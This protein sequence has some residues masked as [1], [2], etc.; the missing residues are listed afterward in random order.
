MGDLTTGVDLCG[1]G[2]IDGN[3]VC[4]DSNQDDFDGCRSDCS[5]SQ[6]LDIYSGVMGSGTCARVYGGGFRCWGKDDYGMLGYG[7]GGNIGDDELAR[8]GGI[9]KIGANA[10]EISLGITHACARYEDGT[11]RCWGSGQ[12]GALGAGNMMIMGSNSAPSLLDVVALGGE[13]VAQVF[14]GYY[15]TCVRFEVGKVSCW[16]YGEAGALGLGNVDNLGDDEKLTPGSFI[17]LGMA[18]AIQ[19]SMGFQHACVLS[20]EGAVRCWGGNFTGQLGLGHTNDI[21]DDELPSSAPEVSIGGPAS[22]ICAGGNFSCALRDNGG[23]R[24]WGGNKFGQLGYGHTNQIG[25][26]ESPASV[27]DV[28][29]GEAVQSVA[30]GG[31]HT[32]VVT[33]GGSVKCWGNNETGA[34]GYG[35]TM[36]I[37]DDET[38]ANVAPVNLGAQAVAVIA[39]DDHTCALLVNGE[40]MCWG[41]GASGRLGYGNTIGIGDDELPSDV[42]VVPYY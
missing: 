2:A 3:E 6:A 9:N 8:D 24:C 18:D 1:N 35:H 10:V 32:C 25:D 16:G 33:V 14:A 36:H 26:N 11:V 22:A 12:Y 23:L 19:L 17:D 30:C 34:L 39:A 28:D 13:S 29:V 21:G 37:G 42:G 4:D 27:G 41:S 5:S 31:L 7:G 38:P 20:S 40:I 15:R